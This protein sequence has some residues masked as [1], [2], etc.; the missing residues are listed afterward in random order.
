MRVLW[1][2]VELVKTIISGNENR[3]NLWRQ[4]CF[5]SWLDVKSIQPDGQL[6]HSILRLQQ[7]FNIEP[8]YDGIYYLFNNNSQSLRFGPREFCVITGF[9]F[10]DNTNKNK[11]SCAFVNRVLFD[12]I[13]I[14]FSVDGLKSFLQENKNNFQDANTVRLSLLLYTLSLWALRR[15]KE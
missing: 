11:G 13:I 6:G 8:E 7:D 3:A 15:T 1:R 10:G 4:Q 14:P 9:S 12:N 2:N 5:G